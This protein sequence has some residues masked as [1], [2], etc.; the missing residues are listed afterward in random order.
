MHFC[1]GFLKTVIKPQSN[2]FSN[3][4]QAYRRLVVHVLF[5]GGGANFIDK[6]KRSHTSILVLFSINTI[7]Q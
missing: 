5:V 6:N 4:E 1:T 3:V 2:E 7:P